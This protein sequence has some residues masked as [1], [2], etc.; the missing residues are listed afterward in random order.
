MLLIMGE[1]VAGTRERE[2]V[3]QGSTEVRGGLPRAKSLFS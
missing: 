1:L 3:M 2:W